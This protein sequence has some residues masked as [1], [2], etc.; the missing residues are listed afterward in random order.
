MSVG[1][2]SLTQPGSRGTFGFD[3]A[4]GSLYQPAPYQ[5]VTP[6]LPN[7]SAQT[8]A[9][10][11]F[12]P[13]R[14]DRY[15]GG[16]AAEMASTADNTMM[17]A[18]VAG[19]QYPH[20]TTTSSVPAQAPTG[21]A[22]QLAQLGHTAS[23]S[24]QPRKSPNAASIQSP[25]NKYPMAAPPLPQ[26]PANQ[27]AASQSASSSPTTPLSPGSQNREQQRVT[28]LLEINVIMLEEVN[29]LQM[30]GKGGAISPQI[31]AQ[32]REKGQNADL[33]SENYI[34]VLR[35]VQANLGYLMPV[36]QNDMQKTAR[37]PAY[38]TAPPHMPQ[39]QTKYDQLKELFPDWQG[40]E[41]RTSMSPRA[42]SASG[43]NGTPVQI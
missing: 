27:Q 36:A 6:H 1:P 33:A 18:Q 23:A 34:Q 12:S 20:K 31:Q 30:E 41:S 10:Q 42:N 40:Y 4:A 11:A 32:M 14:Q 5:S 21:P 7:S 24:P 26:S 19:Q 15:D 38:I 17:P 25:P 43:S 3:N 13:V 39:L 28:L 16:N 29:R 37:G 8:T 2:G 35:R 22:P 9:R